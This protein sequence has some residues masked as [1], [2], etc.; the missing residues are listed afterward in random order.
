[1]IKQ[2]ILILLLA[3]IVFAQWS[4]DPTQNLKV[5]ST[6]IFAKSCSDGNGGVYVVW[7][8][9]SYDNSKVMLQHVD[10]YGYLS[11]ANPIEIGLA[12]NFQFS[13]AHVV[14][15]GEGGVYVA[16]DQITAVD[17]FDNFIVYEGKSYIQRVGSDGTV[18]WKEGGIRASLDSTDQRRIKLINDGEG[19]AI[20]SWID[21]IDGSFDTDNL[22][23]TQKISSSGKRLWTDNGIVVDTVKGG[24]GEIVSDM[25]GGVIEADLYVLYNTSEGYVV[26][27]P[28]VK[29]I[30]KMRKVLWSDSLSFS[31]DLLFDGLRS[32]EHGN[33]VVF[34]EV[35]YPSESGERAIRINY[36]GEYDWGESGIAFPYYKQYFQYLLTF[37]SNDETTFIWK[38]LYDSVEV[39]TMQ[40]F[41]IDGKRKWEEDKLISRIY[42]D[43]E[44]FRMVESN[45]FGN[46]LLY[47]KNNELV[48]YSEKVDSV[49]NSEW[50]DIELANEGGGDITF[51]S[52]GN[53][54]AIVVWSRFLYG[55]FAQ[56]ISK[57][58]NLG[59]V[60]VSVKDEDSENLPS[61]YS[62][63]QNYPNP[64]NPSTTIQYSIPRSTEYYSVSQTTLKVYDILGREVATLVNE[65]QNAGNYEVNFNAKNLSSGIY[66]YRLKSGSFVESK[67]MI[68]LK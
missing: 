48:F 36:D 2:I 16:Y 28:I 29:H 68:L 62:L 10:K 56:Q 30:D 66:Y 57:D 21:L 45:D 27:Y 61:E 33:S 23:Y 51:V 32:D 5:S 46:I 19:N 22:F 49:G 35:V 59:E 8:S 65:K 17:T 7:H 11:W 43:K 26:S 18:L 13:E 37:D 3:N 39:Q 40:K 60:I 44:V 53:G 6:G 9:Y 38:G 63:E 1:M 12:T 14:N 50:A 34:V 64:F 52:D 58:G 42:P 15:D 24:D 20:V 41:T 25:K 54:G 55:I 31:K 47:K 4:T 67:K